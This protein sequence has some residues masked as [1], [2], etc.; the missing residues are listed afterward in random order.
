MTRIGKV[1]IK[2]EDSRRYLPTVLQHIRDGS[3]NRLARFEFEGWRY[4][5]NADGSICSFDPHAVYRRT[6]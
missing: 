2:L 1:T 6:A 5:R 4:R 3:G